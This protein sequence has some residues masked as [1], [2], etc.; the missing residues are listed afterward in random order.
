MVAHRLGWDINWQKKSKMGGPLALDG[1]H[2]MGRHNNQ[3]KFGI[4]GGRGIEEERQPGRNVWGGC[5]LFA[6]SSKSKKKK[7]ANKNMSWP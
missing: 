3:P 7:N 1:H 6:W 5:C 2:L 4:N